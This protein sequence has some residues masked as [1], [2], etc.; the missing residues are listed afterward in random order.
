MGLQSEE[1]WDRWSSAISRGN[2]LSAFEGCPLQ[3]AEG[4]TT[5]DPRP[6]RSL[7]SFLSQRSCLPPQPLAT[8]ACLDWN[9]LKPNKLNTSSVVT[10]VMFQVLTSWACGGHVVAWQGWCLCWSGSFYEAMQLGPWLFRGGGS[11][12]DSNWSSDGRAL[13]RTLAPQCFYCF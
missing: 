12:E 11:L 7:C 6:V 5:D 4:T 3:A 2:L 13:G 10:L 8:H 1:G 9:Q